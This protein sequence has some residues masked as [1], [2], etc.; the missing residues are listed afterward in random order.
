MN[1]IRRIG[2]G[3]EYL[4]LCIDYDE[5]DEDKMEMFLWWF[6]DIV[7]GDKYFNKKLKNVIDKISKSLKYRDED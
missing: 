3:D 4:E 2:K 5:L 7:A 6:Q 1:E